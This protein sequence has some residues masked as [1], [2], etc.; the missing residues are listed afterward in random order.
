MSGINEKKTIIELDEE[1][2]LKGVYLYGMKAEG[3]KSV[4]VDASKLK[5]S[6]GG[7]GGD[8]SGNL[9]DLSDVDAA[10]AVEED[11]LKKV[12]EKWK[13][14]KAEW[15]KTGE[16]NGVKIN[17]I[18]DLITYFQKY[19]IG[20]PATNTPP[21]LYLDKNYYVFRPEDTYTIPVTYY[22]KEGGE[23]KLIGKKPAGTY[24]GNDSSFEVTGL[25]SGSAQLNLK[26]VL[27]GKGSAETFGIGTYRIE[28]I[29]LVDAFGR[30][31]EAAQSI[32]FVVGSVN[33]TS[34]FDDSRQFGTGSAINLDYRITSVAR[35]VAVS[36]TVGGQIMR[37]AGTE[38]TYSTYAAETTEFDIT[39]AGEEAFNPTQSYPQ[40]FTTPAFAEPGEY[41]VQIQAWAKDDTSLK[42]SLLTKRIVVLQDGIVYTTSTLDTNADYRINNTVILPVNIYHNQEGCT[43]KVRA[44][45]QNIES[46]STETAE[47]A[48]KSLEIP[49]ALP[50]EPNTY[51]IC[52]RTTVITPEGLIYATNTKELALNVRSVSDYSVLTASEYKLELY[53]SANGL[54]NSLPD[55]E[56]WKNKYYL[57][58]D[59]KGILHGFLKEINGWVDHQ[60]GTDQRPPEGDNL[61]ANGEAY[62]LV[63]YSPFAGFSSKP[64][65]QGEGMT[66]ELM[67]HN[68]DLYK[69]D[70][71]TFSIGDPTVTTKKGLSIDTQRMLIY[72]S[73]SD[74]L[75]I[76]VRT[77]KNYMTKLGDF[78][79]NSDEYVHITITYD[80]SAKL[81]LVFCNGVI[82]AATTFPDAAYLDTDA[83][84]VVNGH[85]SED[86]TVSGFSDCNVKFLRVYQKCLGFDEV[87]N[88]YIASIYF[89]PDR[90]HAEMINNPN[91]PMLTMFSVFGN[92]YGATKD[93]AVFA[94]CTMTPGQEE[95]LFDKY[96]FSPLAKDV[97]DQ[98]YADLSQRHPLTTKW[99]GNSSLAYP[100][101]N[102]EFEFYD[103]EKLAATGEYETKSFNMVR[104][105]DGSRPWYY[106]KVYQCKANYIDSSSCN[107]QGIAKLF[108]YVYRLPWP[109][110]AAD[111]PAYCNGST[112]PFPYYNVDGDHY[113]K[114]PINPARLA[115]DAV[116]VWFN[117]QHLDASGNL[118]ANEFGGLLTWGLKQQEELYSMLDYKKDAWHKNTIWRSES[119]GDSVHPQLRAGSYGLFDLSSM[120]LKV[121]LLDRPLTQAYIDQMGLVE[122]KDY[123]D[124]DKPERIVMR[125]EQMRWR[126]GAETVMDFECRNPKSLGRGHWE[127]ST[128]GYTWT[129]T[130]NLI[131]PRDLDPNSKAKDRQKRWVWDEWDNEN[132]CPL[133][134]KGSP[135]VNYFEDML[136]AETVP[137]LGSDTGGIGKID[138]ALGELAA[139]Q[140]ADFISAMKWVDTAPDECF[141]NPEIFGKYFHLQSCIDYVIICIV[142]YLSDQLGRNLT[143]VQW[144]TRE[145]DMA[146]RAL[147]GNPPVFYPAG[148]DMDTALGTNVQGTLTED[149]FKG[150]QYPIGNINDNA[151]YY[152]PKDSD[153]Q[154]YNCGENR[155]WRRISA[156]YGDTIIRRY[157]DLRSGVTGQ[158]GKAYDGVLTHNFIISTFCKEIISR[159]GERFYNMD[160]QYKYIGMDYESLDAID[161]KRKYLINARGNKLMFINQFLQDR[162]S[163]V[164]SL[165][166][167]EPQGSAVSEMIYFQHRYNGTFSITMKTEV[168]AFIR[169]SFAQNQSSY[170]YCDGKLPATVSYTY[171]SVGDDA[172][173][174]ILRIYNA[175][176][177]VMIEGFAGKNLTKAKLSTA[178]S[179]RSIDLSNNP[180]LNELE[181]S[182]CRNLEELNLS[183]CN[184]STGFGVDISN[185]VFLRKFLAHNSTVRTGDFTHNPYLTDIDVRECPNV[186]ILN[187]EGLKRVQSVQFTPANIE[188]LNLSNCSANLDIKDCLNLISLT[189][190]NNDH[191]VSLAS[192][193]GFTKLRNL[194]IRNCSRLENMTNFLKENKVIT[195]LP[196]NFLEASKA[197][198]KY[199]DGAFQD[200]MISTYP[201]GFFTNTFPELVSA[202]YTFSGS[203]LSGSIEDHFIGSTKL[204]SVVGCYMQCRQI[205]GNVPNI[206]GKYWWEA[207]PGYIDMIGTGCFRSCFGIDNYSIIPDDWGGNPVTTLVFKS[208]QNKT[209]TGSSLECD[210]PFKKVSETTYELRGEEGSIAHFTFKCTNHEDCTD[211]YQLYETTTL[212][213]TAM[214]IPLR[215]IRVRK[216]NTSQYVSGATIVI[217]NKT[218][219]T[220]TN[221][222]INIRSGAAVRG[223]VE[224]T[225]VTGNTFDYSA[226]LDDTAHVIDVYPDVNVKFIVK[227]DAGEFISNARIT[228][229]GKSGTTNS[230]GECTLLLAKGSHNYLVTSSSYVDTPGTIAVGYS[231]MTVNVAIISDPTLLKPSENGNIQMM[232]SGINATIRISSTDTNYI[233]DWGDGNIDNASGTGTRTYSHTYLIDEYHQIEISNCE[234]ITVCNGGAECMTA[235]WSIGNSKVSNISFANYSKLIYFGD[236]LKNDIDRTSLTSFLSGCNSLVTL[237]LSPLKKLVNLISMQNFCN[238]CTRLQTVDMSALNNIPGINDISCFF[239]GCRE[240]KNIM[241][242]PR[243]TNVNKFIGFMRFCK[244]YIG[245]LPAFWE[246][247]DNGYATTTCFISCSKASN[248]YDVPFEWGGPLIKDRLITLYIFKDN[249]WLLNQNVLLGGQI[250]TQQNDGT[251]KGTV[252]IF[253]GDNKVTIGDIEETLRIEGEL[254]D[255]C[256]T[257]GN[258]E[259]LFKPLLVDF[260]KGINEESILENEGW[261]YDA[262]K[263]GLFCDRYAN[264]ALSVY[265]VFGPIAFRS[266]KLTV[267]Y[268]N[269]GGSFGISYYPTSSY[270]SSPAEG[271]NLTRDMMIS[272]GNILLASNHRGGNYCCVKKIEGSYFCPPNLPPDFI[273]I[274]PINA[275]SANNVLELEQRLARVERMLNLKNSDHAN[276]Q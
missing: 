180:A 116:P 28:D 32:T 130:T 169:V 59:Y 247:I 243:F 141:A 69:D 213:Y 150:W 234:E 193:T 263:G 151:K 29:F 136:T 101:K 209:I 154:N 176:P 124:L 18:E 24:T 267:T 221:G 192:K 82:S 224:A 197:T 208:S 33:V 244:N 146:N 145:I 174:K 220:D 186:S 257:I 112:N 187:L 185:C 15:L 91:K 60:D 178:S 274:S 50:D 149:A 52:L 19:G 58:Q 44:W 164:D 98:R 143:F 160:A 191:I 67:L 49:F 219:T 70:S 87:L 17:T 54:S 119:N 270:S 201:E 107:N 109:W 241:G 14:V 262:E 251:Y 92:I 31:S 228:C 30:R 23:L 195:E 214:Y 118:R 63:N 121:D 55:W 153:F 102:W 40:T 235:Y 56:T 205:T 245:E 131:D 275:L 162:L 16:L 132:N 268:D 46:I 260:S 276:I 138:K 171:Q 238:K 196:K 48:I 156:L 7:G 6:G 90:Q 163:Y 134:K 179:L 266:A 38:L 202:N 39:L 229:S 159:I 248:Y 21:I 106:T 242:M 223:S 115:I 269:T 227:N 217:G 61:H 85:R 261:I 256:L 157:R 57:N 233:I 78:I 152:Q 200:T 204:A 37:K 89:D 97:E 158:D 250:L 246:Y 177:I 22:D 226:I 13:S 194:D 27:F 10:D 155:F 9:A 232:L 94:E 74:S 147:K 73:P 237:D 253:K 225:G 95:T 144:D 1:T 264:I 182:G 203:A 239:D 20:Y 53:L 43:Y 11:I 64:A 99:Q 66:I 258:T 120:P 108:D 126:V 139:Q 12:G 272:N 45:V 110:P 71:H 72:Y 113:S 114:Y 4:K 212:N 35:E 231:D 100:V 222:Y 47:S 84:V 148:Y 165:F 25:G 5:V 210:A 41:V 122:G 175:A 249:N 79:A 140:H 166:R 105:A 218:Y 96:I 190:V 167:Y 62:C 265:P 68:S 254:N 104:H 117:R 259:G 26:D 81:I 240:L 236:V 137:F 125:A 65:R 206:G 271:I 216:Y 168:P 211:S 198:I 42:S 51:T 161:A 123:Y 230:K 86:G 252:T 181:L 88:N 36:V 199:L 76:P 127:V 2:D 80:R 273:P 135:A 3:P 103:P 207:R 133:R 215:T 184:L 83:P 34:S 255:Y 170:V 128:N 8:F 77:G 173:E 183:G 111:Y 93:D 129:R 189:V 75:S 188:E 172:S 142:L